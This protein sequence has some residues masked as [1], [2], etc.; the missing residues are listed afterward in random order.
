MAERV[1]R[2]LH[3][4]RRATIAIFVALI[5]LTAVAIGALSN[6][7][8]Y[9]LSLEATLSV[10]PLLVACAAVLT[11]VVVTYRDPSSRSA[12][13]ALTATV[14]G[15]VLA[16]VAHRS[17]FGDWLPRFKGGDVAS[18]GFAQLQAHGQTLSYALELHNP[19]ARSHK[20][21]VIAK[22]GSETHQIQIR[23]FDRAAGGYGDALSPEEWIILR[24]TNN[25]DVY[26]AVISLN[27]D[28]RFQLDLRLDT[29]KPLAAPPRHP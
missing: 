9:G 3:A 2:S 28:K 12:G 29:S 4:M 22:R 13:L 5:T 11:I 23:V 6:W 19:F 17:A 7:F 16:L 26:E 14:C 15:I 20:E 27:A 21:F 18:S 8:R 25:R 1:A 24:P 10:A